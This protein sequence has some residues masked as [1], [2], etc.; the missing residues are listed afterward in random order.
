MV[1]SE[2][3]ASPTGDRRCKAAS[4]EHPDVRCERRVNGLG[5]HI[6]LNHCAIVPGQMGV[7]YWTE[8]AALY[9]NRG[10]AASERP[11]KAAHKAA[12]LQCEKMVTDLTTHQGDHEAWDPDAESWL[13][14]TDLVSV[15]VDD[16]AGPNRIEPKGLKS[17]KLDP[18]PATGTQVGGDHYLRAIQP[19]D[20][21]DVWGLDYWR[22][23]ALTY[24]L[25]AGNKGAAVDDLKKARHLLDYLIEREERDNG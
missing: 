22:G 13:R 10:A 2:E 23:R 11:C 25:R 14:W 1:S 4:L 8:P 15:H 17:V 9:P 20:I 3:A 18:V 5:N 16:L 7:F 19:W 12:R 21:I 24:L 6:G